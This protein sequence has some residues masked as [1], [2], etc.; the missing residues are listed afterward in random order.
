MNMKLGL[1]LFGMAWSNTSFHLVLLDAAILYVCFSF[2][3]YALLGHSG[4]G[5][6]GRRGKEGDGRNPAVFLDR[7]TPAKTD[8]ARQ[9]TQCTA[10]FVVSIGSI[11][12]GCVRQVK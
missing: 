11:S 9:V 3:D 6:P 5:G 4:R 12:D 2:S 8:M 10:N 7:Q 1:S